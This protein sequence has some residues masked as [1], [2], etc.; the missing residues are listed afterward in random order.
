MGLAVTALS[1]AMLVLYEYLNFDR[2]CDAWV[3][4]QRVNSS[5]RN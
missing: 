5:N 3:N 4:T 1:N 2:N